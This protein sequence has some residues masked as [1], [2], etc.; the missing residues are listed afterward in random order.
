MNQQRERYLKYYISTIPVNKL[1]GTYDGIKG[2][3]SKLSELAPKTL[4][5][6]EKSLKL[7]FEDFV[8]VYEKYNVASISDNAAV[9]AAVDLE[10]RYA[11]VR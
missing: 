5:R 9:N 7:E 11:V 8:A 2:S 6:A 1:Q 3:L 10:F 4:S